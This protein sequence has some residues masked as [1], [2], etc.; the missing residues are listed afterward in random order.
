MVLHYFCKIL[1][2]LLFRNRKT[3]HEVHPSLSLLC[4]GLGCQPLT[5][6]PHMPHKPSQLGAG[7]HLPCPSQLFLSSLSCFK[8]KLWHLMCKLTSFTA[9]CAQCVAPHW[10]R[11]LEMFP[12]LC[13]SQWFP[14]ERAAKEEVFLKLQHYWLSARSPLSDID[15][16]FKKS[17]FTKNLI[18]F[19]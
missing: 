14:A 13:C 15:T 4:R 8:C 17:F 10:P 16:L 9:L 2:F 7:M 5:H 6:Q 18:L 12:L 1:L 11:H 19:T 3:G